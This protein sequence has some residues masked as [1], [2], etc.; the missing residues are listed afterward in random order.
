MHQIGLE[1][2]QVRDEYYIFKP[3]MWISKN[4]DKNSIIH[5]ITLFEYFAGV[6]D[7]LI[8]ITS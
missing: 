8:Y 2:F 6:H 3:I 1:N 4:L 7:G 5:K